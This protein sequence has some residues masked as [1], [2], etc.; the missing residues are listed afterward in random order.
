MLVSRAKTDDLT[1][2]YLPVYAAE[3]PDDKSGD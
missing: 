2:E 3:V 1:S